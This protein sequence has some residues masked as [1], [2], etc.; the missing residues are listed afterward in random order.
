MYVLTSASRA[1][2]CHAC[3]DNA[4]MVDDKAR[5][6]VRKVTPSTWTG[7]GRAEA[8]PGWGCWACCYCWRYVPTD[9]PTEQAFNPQPPNMRAVLPCCDNATKVDDKAHLCCSVCS[10]CARL[11]YDMEVLRCISVCFL[12]FFSQASSLFIW[13]QLILLDI[14]RDLCLC[15]SFLVR[16]AGGGAAPSLLHPHPLLFSNRLPL[17]PTILFVFRK[18]H[19][20]FGF[21]LSLLISIEICAIMYFFLGTHCGGRAQ[22]PPPCTPPPAFI[23]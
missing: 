4:T 12:F 5:Q 9:Q 3:C 22:R 18:H 16:I 10:A 23:S 11:L 17:L 2:V 21:I 20:L 15:T 1:C 7:W 19:R 14:H 8:S 6:P 13:V